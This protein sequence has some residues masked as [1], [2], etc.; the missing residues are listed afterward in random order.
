MAEAEGD[1]VRLNVRHMG[2]G[3]EFADVPLPLNAPLSTVKEN[4][5]RRT[6]TEPKNMCLTLVGGTSRTECKD[7]KNS[8]K[9]YNVANGMSLEV[10]DLD[11]SS[12]P[13][14]LNE[15]NGTE[16]NAYREVSGDAGFAAAR[17]AMMKAKPSRPATED[18]D[19]EAAKKFKEGQRI[20]SKSTGKLGTIRFI[21]R[22]EVLPKGWWV[23]VELDSPT[24]KN[25]GEVKGIRLFTC[26]PNKGAVMRPSTI[27]VDDE[28][29][30]DGN[31]NHSD[32]EI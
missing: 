8:L 28:S 18:T 20:K 12:I 5:H 31:S 7:D 2:L 25:D 16:S 4:L 3:M 21:G 9:D 24:G 1:V 29:I 32:D 22:V 13:N 11:T 30:F 27:D 26:G 19:A 17:K 10:V 23:G 14:T 6:G 15:S